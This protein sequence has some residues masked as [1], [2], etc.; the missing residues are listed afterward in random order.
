MAQSEKLAART[1]GLHVAII[2]DGNG[3][4]AEAQGLPRVAGHRAGAIAVHRVVRAAPALGVSTLT[5][6]ALS[7]DNWKRPEQE[8]QALLALL[9][10]YLLSE[11]PECVANGVALRVIGRRDRLPTELVLAIEAAEE[12][13][14]S[15]KRLCL[16][17]AID[18][19]SRDAIIGAARAFNVTMA[20]N[21][22]HDG[23]A[24]LL[25]DE[26]RASSAPCTCVEGAHGHGVHA[27]AADADGAHADAAHT[28]G[29]HA[30]GSHAEK[31]ERGV[32]CDPRLAR[33]P[34]PGVRNSDGGAPWE[35]ASRRDVDLLIRSGG[36][37]RLSDFLLWECAYAEI[38]F[39]KRMWP[40]FDGT[41]LRK[42]IQEFR[43]RERRFG[44]LRAS[45]AG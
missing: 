42:A 6:F 28:D 18:Y 22:S 21:G 2:M 20:A 12:A 39:T 4:W 26:R 44:G 34:E 14:R 33:Q 8:V 23:F 1:H 36:E 43:S 45:D 38:V 30:H 11:T 3:R 9:R 32:D 19:S 27:D 25:A 41:A 40:E 7:A 16:R 13:T 29:A 10:E 5:L 31:L 24:A 17:L 35:H 37:Q 15:G